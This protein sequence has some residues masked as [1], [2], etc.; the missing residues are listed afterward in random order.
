MMSL[1]SRRFLLRFLGWAILTGIVGGIGW[2]WFD[3]HHSKYSVFTRE[4]FERSIAA[5]PATIA[6]WHRL[7]KAEG[8]PPYSRGTAE[9]R[10]KTVM[11]QRQPF[12]K[13]DGEVDWFP[14]FTESDAAWEYDVPCM[15]LKDWLP[16]FSQF[17]YYSYDLIF[18]GEMKIIGYRR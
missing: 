3:W 13:K 10:L 8:A 18:T 5:R 2:L 1:K 7:I 11:E 15:E 4:K 17:N 6:D 16:G 12:K 9:E 14:G